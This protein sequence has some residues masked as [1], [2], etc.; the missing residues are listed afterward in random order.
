VSKLRRGGAE[1]WS[2]EVEGGRGGGKR[3][4]EGERM[5]MGIEIR[6]T[7]MKRHG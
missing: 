6:G 3:K 2:E 1:E 7:G 5:G 4:E